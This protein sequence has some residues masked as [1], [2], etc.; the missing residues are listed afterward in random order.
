[1]YKSPGDKEE[2]HEAPWKTRRCWKPQKE[3]WRKTIPR[4][5]L[6]WVRDIEVQNAGGDGLRGSEYEYSEQG[7]SAQALV[8]LA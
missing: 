7:G 3:V 1:M 5:G 6:V 2:Y 8:T 4:E